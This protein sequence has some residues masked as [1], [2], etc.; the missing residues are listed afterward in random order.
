M[1]T[2][3]D[4]TF[5]ALGKSVQIRG[6]GNVT[7][8]LEII[9][10]FLQSADDNWCHPKPCA[11]GRTY[12]P[13]VQNI[14]FYAIA[15]FQYAPTYLEAIDKHGRLDLH[16]LKRNAEIYCQKVRESKTG[17]FRKLILYRCRPANTPLS[18]FHDD[19][20][21]LYNF[22]AIPVILK[23]SFFSFDIKITPR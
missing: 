22:Q 4:T 21:Y 8:C 18:C 9:N 16:L 2:S 1:F 12:Q 19:A 20:Q 11:I 13:S 7:K 5:T 14:V 10:I 6:S 15:A 3:D 17:I 23:A